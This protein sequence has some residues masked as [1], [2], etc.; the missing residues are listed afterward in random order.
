MPYYKDL[1]NKLHWL[2]SSETEHVLPSGAIQISD[3][4]AIAL[5]PKPSA[6]DI[7]LQQITALESTI[8]QRR[9]RE[10]TSTDAGKAWLLNVD[11]QIATLRATL[12]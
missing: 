1:N 3:A 5:M 7:I 2:D 4:D 12:S 10:A 6:N 8:T 9:L 11:T